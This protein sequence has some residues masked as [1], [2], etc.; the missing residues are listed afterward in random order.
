M[1]VETEI[2]GLERQWMD[3]WCQKHRETCERILANDFVLTSAR[4]VLMSKAEWLLNAMGPFVCE[5]FEWEDLRVRPLTSEVA[6]VHARARQRAKVAGQDWSGVFLI[7]DVWV[8]REG[9]WRV[10]ARHGT[11]PLPGS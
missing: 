6:L 1:N 4:G 8:R 9:H 3:G 11:G 5:H 10:V 2:A 7:T